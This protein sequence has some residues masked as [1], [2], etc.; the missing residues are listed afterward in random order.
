M[1]HESAQSMTSKPAPVRFGSD[2]LQVPAAPNAAAEVL[3][4]GQLLEELGFNFGTLSHHRF[5]AGNPSA[6]FTLLGAVAARTATLCLGSGVVVLPTYHPLDLAEQ[7][8]TLDQISNGR[9][10]YGVGV[11]YMPKEYEAVGLGFRERGRRMDECMQ[12]IRAAGRDEGMS[13]SG[14]HF[15]FNDVT[16]YPR[17][18]QQPGPPIWVGASSPPAIR[19][20]AMLGDALCLGTQ[21]SLPG[22]VPLV[23]EY[24][25]MAARLNRPSAFCLQRM[26]AIGSTRELERGWLATLL[27]KRALRMSKGALIERQPFDDKK[28]A[29]EHVDLEEVTFDRA[30]VGTPEDCIREIEKCRALTECEYIALNLDGFK[31]EPGAVERQLRLFATEVMP[32]FA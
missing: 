5:M 11:G 18:V 10:F 32:A 19:R 15:T 30:V 29:G 27:E 31:D 4:R 12:I 25:A 3:E 7:V 17:P 9:A 26:I 24:R 13:F 14:T 8:H 1:N 28:A 16:V 20:A 23:D 22:V 6:P 21:D 2:L